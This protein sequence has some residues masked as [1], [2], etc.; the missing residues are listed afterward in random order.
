MQTDKQKGRWTDKQRSRQT[1][2]QTGLTSQ[3]TKKM[4]C[5]LANVHL[6]R[7]GAGLTD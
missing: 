6:D 1:E 7:Q 4:T 2:K 5:K 3:P